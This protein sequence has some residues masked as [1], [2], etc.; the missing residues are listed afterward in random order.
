MGKLDGKVVLLTG[1]SSGIGKQVSIKMAEEGAKL[2]ICARRAGKL[3]ETKELC[4]KAG[5]E[6]IAIPCDLSDIAAIENLVKETVAHFGKVDVL[7][8]NAM[9]A[10]MGVPFLKQT[11][12]DLDKVYK[13]NLVAT[14][15]LMQ[16]CHPYM[17]ANGGGSIINTGSGSAQNGIA[18]YASYASIKGAVITLTKVAANEWGA[19]NIRANLVHPVAYTDAIEEGFIRTYGDKAQ[20][21]IEFTKMQLRNNPLNRIGD[22][23]T[24]IAPVFVFL[25]SEDSRYMTGQILRAEGGQLTI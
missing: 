2:A 21:I 13:S 9:S 10:T 19:D 15:K 11:I 23:Y 18:N 8:N 20:E 7:V 3:Q 14:W 12:E 25:A 17:K 5:A 22:A 4:E 6:V 1:A 16:L 24:D